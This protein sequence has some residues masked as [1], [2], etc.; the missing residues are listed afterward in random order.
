M[1]IEV[2]GATAAEMP[3]VLDMI[4]RV[5]GASREYFAAAYRN[6]PWARPE[7]SRIARADGRI[8]SHIR[9]Y[10]RWQRVG[11]IPVHVG[12]VGDVC[13][14][15]EYRKQGHC[16]ALLEDA[17][18]YWDDHG[19][20]LS[21]IVSGVG[22]YAACGWVPLPEPGFELPAENRHEARSGSSYEARRFV[23]SEDLTAVAAVYATYN[24]ARSLTT[25]RPPAYWERHFAWIAGEIE[26]AFLV[27]EREGQIVAYLRSEGGGQRLTLSE[28]CYLPG[29]EAAAGD[30]LDAALTFAAKRRI[31]AVQAHLPADHAALAEARQ[32]P[33]FA[34][35]QTSVLLFRLVNL[36]RL[37]DRLRPLLAERAR[38]AGVEGAFTL[39]V[40]DQA[41]ELRV[42]PGWVEVG[43]PESTRRQ[44]VLEPAALFALLFGAAEPDDSLAGVPD[45]AARLLAGLFPAGAPV[46]WRTDIV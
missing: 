27:A 17:L 20:D 33:G 16:R 14:L 45:E 18:R 15:P 26:E 43:G 31:P 19:Y 41:A 36:Y 30:L 2:R 9:L 8:V 29:H 40:G 44:I 28:C 46:Y 22:V 7:H 5:M 12:C 25:L 1:P 38:A 34:V 21:M 42:R 4:P 37:L 11:S 10:D 35:T 32:R 6:D 24:A 39:E 13:T 3:E 23:R